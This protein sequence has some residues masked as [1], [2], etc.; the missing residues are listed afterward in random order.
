MVIASQ[1]NDV[2]DIIFKIKPCKS[3]INRNAPRLGAAAEAYFL[4][5]SVGSL[6]EDGES[7]ELK[8]CAFYFFVPGL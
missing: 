1:I 3:F 7:D 2:G 4:D 6:K 5:S 8:N